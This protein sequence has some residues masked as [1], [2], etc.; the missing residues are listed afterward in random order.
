[1]T[2]TTGNVA[3][4]TTVDR[5]SDAAWFSTFMDTANALAEY[6]RIRQTLADH[7]GDLLHKTVLDA[8]C[9]NGEDVFELAA[10]VGRYGR[11]VGTDISEAMVAE[12]RRRAEGRDVPVA[13]RVDDVRRLSFDDETF[14]ATRAKL[15]LMHLPDIGTAMAEL[16]RV[17]RR[18]GRIA[19]F[20]YDFDTT[21]VD[22]PD[23]AVTREIVR[24]GSD[25]HPNN[26]AGRQMTRRFLELGLTDVRVTPH[27]VVMPFSFFHTS[28]G[29]RLATAQRDGTLG[30]SAGQLADWWR[31]LAEADARGRFFAS[32]TGFAVSGT[33]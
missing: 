2:A 4:F 10:L 6:A 26:W 32:L 3:Q 33:R 25:G 15:V 18:G 12:A 8:G 28:V 14:S 13:F 1:M 23:Q 7:L 19:V 9:G 30:M 29:G 22:H 16:V 27:T 5:A 24:C 20:D 11:V 21:T 31:P 17:T